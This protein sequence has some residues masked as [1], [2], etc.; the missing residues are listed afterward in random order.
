LRLDDAIAGYER[1][2]PPILHR[3]RWA[4]WRFGRVTCNWQSGGG[5]PE[6][7]AHRRWS[8]VRFTADCTDVLG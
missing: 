1:V 7:R 5:T 8:F 4:R 6:L 2:L 3:L